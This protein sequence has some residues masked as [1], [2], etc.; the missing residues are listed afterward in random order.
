MGEIVRDSVY[1]PLLAKIA[2]LDARVQDLEARDWVGVWEPNKSYAKG[3]LIT[4]DGSTWVATRHYPEKSPGL[5][6]S[7]WRLIC[8]RGRDGRDAK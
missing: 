2:L 3:S 4:A 6:N 8:K 5:P 7:G 1:Q